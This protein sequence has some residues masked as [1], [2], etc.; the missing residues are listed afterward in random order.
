VRRTNA[1]V[2]LIKVDTEGGGLGMLRGGRRTLA[3]QMPILAMAVYHEY[4]ELFGIPRFMKRE[5]PNYRFNWQMHSFHASALDE[6]TFWAYPGH[7]DA[8]T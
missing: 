6:L 4:N 3:A 7:L 5:F 1:T 2:G 8:G